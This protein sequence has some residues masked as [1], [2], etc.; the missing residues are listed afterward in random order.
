MK[1]APLQ[2][3]RVE[4][5][6]EAHRTR[7]E[8]GLLPLLSRVFSY[9]A[10]HRRTLRW[11]TFHVLL[12]AALLPL[13]TWAMGEVINGPIQ[14]RDAN[15]ILLGA[16]GFAGLAAFTNW[17]FHYR[18]RYALEL[19][20]AVIH[21]LRAAVFAHV[22]RMPMRYFDTTKVGRV[23][24]RVTSDIDSIRTGVQDVVFITAVQVGQMLVA[25]ALMLFHDWFLF[26]VVLA[27]TPVVWGIN[28]LFA[29]RLANAQ[30]DA[31]E[32]YSRITATL[33]ESVSGIRLTQG[34]VREALNAESFRALAEDQ[35]RFNM[36]SART[37]ARFLP[38]LEASTHLF[39]ALL[40]LVGGWRVLAPG[41]HATVGD[42]VQFFFLAVLL[43]EPIRNL[44][45]QYTAAL[46]AMVGAE[47]VFQL[48]DTPPEWTDT[49]DAL[50][51]PRAGAAEGK[52]V[53]VEFHDVNFAYEPGRPVLHDISF[54]A[55]PGMTVA[56][57]G[58]TGSGKTSIT[59]LLAK[60]YLPDAGTISLDGMDLSHIQSS[61]LHEQM[62]I[63]QQQSFLFD[64]TVLDNIRFARSQASEEEV[65]DI[66]RH[67][68]FL[69]DIEAL[70]QGFLTEV[71]EGGAN[72]SGGQRQ[73]VSFA[74]ALLVRPRLLIL[75]EATSAMDALTEARIQF[76]L[77]A[78]LEGRTSFVVAHRL[79]TIRRADL[80]LVLEEGRIVERGTHAELVASCGVYAR[81]HE[82]FVFGKGGALRHAPSPVQER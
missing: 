47:R 56:L 2:L 44:G 52:G 82:R 4:R 42:I 70:P 39:T 9:A 75:D 54:T 18:Y 8:L 19:G 6:P 15:G 7:P 11:L 13:G 78:L 34:F 26:L 32:S 67:L 40:L 45:N 72:L 3:T 49:P 20:E 61:S 79:S 53:L 22:L 41:E 59:N 60:M 76:A 5:D 48:L 10:P 77:A 81:L 31:T 63:V 28:R 21:D 33:T 27:I 80:I 69:E 35:G 14:H 25:S 57:V 64:G 74:R 23:I 65:R 62:G 71:G 24:G 29:K 68:G 66:T 55:R 12:R 46:S 17:M 73:L 30:R 38:L 37:S 51:L 1:R 43:F 50:P 58:A 36:I 16:L